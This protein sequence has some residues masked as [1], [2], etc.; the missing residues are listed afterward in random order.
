MP[1]PH[2]HLVCLLRDERVWKKRI[3]F[4]KR[5]DKRKAKGKD[6]FHYTVDFNGTVLSA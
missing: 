2:Q 1:L 4:R 5:G 6:F 3:R